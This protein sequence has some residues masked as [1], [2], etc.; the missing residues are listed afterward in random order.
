MGQFSNIPPNKACLLCDHPEE[1]GKTEYN[2][3]AQHLLVH[4]DDICSVDLLAHIESGCPG[5]VLLDGCATSC[6]L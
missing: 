2:S 5:E 6:T 4:C 1:V 3:H